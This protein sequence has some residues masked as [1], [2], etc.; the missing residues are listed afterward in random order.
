MRRSLLARVRLQVRTYS[1][2]DY[3]WYWWV[4]PTLAVPSDSILIVKISE[5]FGIFYSIRI[6]FFPTTVDKGTFQEE[7]TLDSLLS[8]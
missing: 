4:T 8:K 3:I 7:W 5:S 1:C 2:I 6:F